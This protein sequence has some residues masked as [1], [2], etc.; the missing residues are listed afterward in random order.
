[1]PNERT[2][3]CVKIMKYWSLCL[4]AFHKS[5]LEWTLSPIWA[6]TNLPQKTKFAPDAFVIFF[7]FIFHLCN[8][9]NH[10]FQEKRMLEVC[11]KGTRY[12]S[13]KYSLSESGGNW[14][15]L[16]GLTA[17]RGLIGMITEW[18]CLGSTEAT[19]TK[20]VYGNDK[21]YV[22]LEW[23]FGIRKVLEIYF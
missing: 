4:I 20:G 19:Q 14:S 23:Y 18:V 9:G 5:F 8:E 2:D 6:Q 15:H 7:L 16:V 12:D 1:M 10:T 13:K 3:V 21:A 17:V 11:T 22:G